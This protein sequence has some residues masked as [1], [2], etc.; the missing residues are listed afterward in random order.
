MSSPVAVLQLAKLPAVHVGLQG[1]SFHEFLPMLGRIFNDA[2]VFESP[3]DNMC[4]TKTT[5]DV[6]LEQGPVL[7]V[8]EPFK[9][10]SASRLPRFTSLSLS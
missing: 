7:A 6:V 1:C 9:L 5:G 4:L 2:G 3:T 10:I 8:M